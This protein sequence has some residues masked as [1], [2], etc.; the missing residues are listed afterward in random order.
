MI[1]GSRMYQSK[2]N[3]SDAALNG[4]LN[5]A[6]TPTEYSDHYYNTLANSLWLGSIQIDGGGAWEGHIKFNISQ[7]DTLIQTGHTSLRL[8]VPRTI[9]IKY[10]EVVGVTHAA[11]QHSSHTSI[12]ASV[13][14]CIKSD[15]KAWL[16]GGYLRV[17]C[18][19]GQTTPLQS[20][21]G[22]IFL[23]VPREPSQ[24]LLSIFE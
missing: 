15:T 18:D 8:L 7:P 1:P 11:H 10:P 22:K 9:M 5:D 17:K 23:A 19:L 12:V 24:C 6:V 20:V 16:R 14:E 4:L 21:R 3:L 13:E 2:T